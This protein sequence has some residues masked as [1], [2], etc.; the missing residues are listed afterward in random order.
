[1]AEAA[2]ALAT[3][4][5]VLLAEE[6]DD[7]GEEVGWASGRSWARLWWAAEVSP[8]EILSSVFYFCF[9]LFCSVLF[10]F[11]KILNHFIKS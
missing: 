4:L 10:W 7:K 3:H 5:V 8:G 2:S 1:M 6:E 11:S 9:F